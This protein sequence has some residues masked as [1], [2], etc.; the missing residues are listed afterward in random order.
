MALMH[1]QRR[2]GP[3]AATLLAALLAAACS[4]AGHGAPTVSADPPDQPRP[5]CAGRVNQQ[6]LDPTTP[7]QIQA[8]IRFRREHGLQAD[9]PYVLSMAC[10]PGADVGFGVPLS[11]A[12][13]AEFGRRGRTTH[14]MMP[15]VQ[16]YAD[17]HPDEFGGVYIDQAKGG[18]LEVLWTAHVAEHLAALRALVHPDAPIAVRQ[19]RW[20]ERELR[21]VQNLISGDWDWFRAIPAAPQG[22]GVDTTRNVVE[23]DISSANHAASELIVAHYGMPAGM[24][25][26]ES[27]GTGAALLPWVT[28]KGI[29]V[30][31]NGTAPGPN[32]LMVQQ[33]AGGQPGE[34]G[35][36]DVAF[37]VMDNGR[38]EYPCQVGIRVIEVVEI[39]DAEPHRVLGSGRLEV[40]A[41]AVVRLRIVID[42]PA[43]P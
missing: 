19:V 27:D 9:L 38:F 32:S 1:R 23:V 24:I 43:Q 26:V 2:A 5:A 13:I 30:R 34:C 4:S 7:E 18:V 12:E 15:V 22:V 21:R 20:S 28:I 31:R 33:R 11:A 42:E 6:R 29:V 8:A 16:A 10:L 40:K 25:V 17:Q 14:A 41:N 3:V 35:G 37:G 39:G 36:G